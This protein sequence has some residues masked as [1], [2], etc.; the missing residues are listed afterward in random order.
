MG[1]EFFS[2]EQLTI[3]EELSAVLQN[4][5]EAADGQSA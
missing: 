4:C 2:E 1:T 5:K 3:V